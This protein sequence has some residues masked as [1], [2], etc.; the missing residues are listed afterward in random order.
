MFISTNITI[1][2]NL[3]IGDEGDVWG[4]ESKYINRKLYSPAVLYTCI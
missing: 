4:K 3:T 1:Y 2:L